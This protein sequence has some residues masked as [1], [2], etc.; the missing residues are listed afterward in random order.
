MSL[1]KILSRKKKQPKP[2][3][4]EAADNKTPSGE[5]TPEGI[6]PETAI[7][8]PAQLGDEKFNALKEMASAINS[9]GGSSGPGFS[10][11][12]LLKMDTG[13]E[14][15]AD[16][17]EIPVGG[18]EKDMYRML[19]RTRLTKYQIGLFTRGIFTAQHGFGLPP[20]L[21]FTVPA[22]GELIVWKL[23]GYVSLD[24]ASLGVFERTT[25][26]WVRSLYQAQQ[27]E[28]AKRNRGINQ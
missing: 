2:V 18:K 8:T 1:D 25:S 15:I 26:M 14:G 19:E 5:T 27:E 20:H 28:Q 10:M 22:L 17:L 7:G 16:V 3:N 9:K 11:T 6:A 21:D 4:P 23:R 12:D 24:G 13:N